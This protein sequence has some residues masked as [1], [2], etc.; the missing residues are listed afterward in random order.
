MEKKVNDIEDRNQEINQK[1]EEIGHRM[2]HNDREIQDLAD[3]IRR[4]NTR[5]MGIIEG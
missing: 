3:T 2:K 5:I 1:G 4:G